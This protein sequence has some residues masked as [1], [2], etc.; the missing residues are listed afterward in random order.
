[1]GCK[2]KQYA[3]SF[4][5][6][7]GLLCIYTVVVIITIYTETETELWGTSSFDEGLL[8]DWKIVTLFWCTVCSL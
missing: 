2:R 7:I 6:F 3:G 5:L 8:G 1:M 4:Q